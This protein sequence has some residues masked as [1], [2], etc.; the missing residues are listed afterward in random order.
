MQESCY[1]R[2]VRGLAPASSVASRLSSEASR[3]P[4]TLG[5]PRRGGGGQSSHKPYIYI[6]IYILQK[7]RKTTM[8]MQKKILAENVILPTES[9]IWFRKK[10][11]KN[12]AI[13]SDFCLFL[14]APVKILHI[15]IGYQAGS[16][17][18]GFTTLF[19]VQGQQCILAA[20]SN[21]C[22]KTLFGTMAQNGC[23]SSSK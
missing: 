2:G 3:S 15:E 19:R 23:T 1:L 13:S 21:R 17:S 14:V 10:D 18:G 8:K 16:P 9:G 22:I 7:I 11:C 5:G 4:Y 20:A 6:Y 12:E